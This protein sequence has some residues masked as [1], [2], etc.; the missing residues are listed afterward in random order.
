MTF[1]RFARFSQRRKYGEAVRVLFRPAK[2]EIQY[3]AESD[4]L[5]HVLVSR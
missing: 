5:A 4:P 2:D 3:Y 1:F